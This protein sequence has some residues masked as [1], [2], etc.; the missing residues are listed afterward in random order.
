MDSS[1]NFLSGRAPPGEGLV[2][3]HQS[4]S[5]DRYS[6]LK[7]PVSRSGVGHY[8]EG[9][10]VSKLVSISVHSW[11][12]DLTCILGRMYTLPL[13]HL[14]IA[15]FG[16]LGRNCR[17][18]TLCP[19]KRFCYPKAVVGAGERLQNQPFPDVEPVEVTKTQQC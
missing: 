2:T 10:C 17:C 12:K 1:S 14:M 8:G 6:P 19:S 3:L 5:A 15:E 11:L 16:I 18:D 9:A 13:N 7:G 4:A